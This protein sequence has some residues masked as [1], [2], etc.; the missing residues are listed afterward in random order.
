MK[1][2]RV[3]LCSFILI[4][5]FIQLFLFNSCFAFGIYSEPMKMQYRKH[6]FMHGHNSALSLLTIGEGSAYTRAENGSRRGNFTNEPVL[7][8]NGD[9]SLTEQD[10]KI[11]GKGLS[12]D[13]TRVYNSQINSN[14][15]G[16]SSEDGS[17]SW[18]IENMEYSGDGGGTFS[19]CS[20]QDAVIEADLKTI[21]PGQ[22]DNEAGT[23]YFRFQSDVNYYFFLIH[24]DGTLELG[25]WRYSLVQQSSAYNPLEWNHIKI[26]TTG[27]LV[28]IYVNNNLEISYTDPTPI[29]SGRVGLVSYDSHAHFDNVSVNDNSTVIQN[30]DFE[31]NA[32]GWTPEIGSGPWN[33][34]Q[35]AYSGENG[36]SVS[37]TSSLNTTLICQMKTIVPGA[38]V[39]DV[40]WFNFRYQNANNRYYFYI[41][42]D[43][44]LVLGRFKN[45][46]QTILYQGTNSSYDPLY[47]NNL[48]ISAIQG[49]IRVWINELLVAQAQDNDPLPEGKVALEAKNSHAHFDNISIRNGAPAL[50]NDFNAPELENNTAFGNGWT[51]TYETKIFEDPQGGFIT[52]RGADGAKE[53]YIKKSDGYFAS[54]RGIYSILTK[55]A[56]GYTLREKDG[57][58]YTFDLNGNLVSIKDRNNNQISISYADIGGIQRPQSATDASGR[59]IIFE[60]GLNGK[61]SKITYPASEA[62]GYRQINY[63]YDGS[64]LIEVDFPSGCKKIY[65]Y[66]PLT[67]NL[68]TYTDSNNQ[69]TTYNYYYSDK[70][71]EEID[72]DNQLTAFFYSADSTDVVNSRNEYTTYTFGGADSLL[73]STVDTLYQEEINTWDDNHNL[74]SFQDKL[75]R[76]TNYEYDA[77]G[78]RTKITKHINGLSDVVTNFTYE[79][80]FNQVTSITDPKGNI[81]QFIYDPANGNLLKIIDPA[82]F[83]YETIMTYDEFGNLKTVTDAKGNIAE[84]EYDQYGN[85]TKIIEAKGVLNYTTNF[86]Y[87]VLSQLTITTDANGHSNT[88]EYDKA[89]S[90]IKTTDSLGNVTQNSYDGNGNRLTQ[91][92]YL[93][94]QPITTSYQYDWANNLIKETK[95]DNIFTTYTYDLA[96]F[97]HLGVADRLT[98]TDAISKTTAYE[99]DSENRLIKVTDPNNNFTQYTYDYAGNLTSIA[100]A[101][102]HTINYEYDGLNRLIYVRYPDLT[103]EAFTYDGNGNLLTKTKQNGDIITYAYD[104]LNRMISKTYPDTSSVT[105]QYDSVD[106]LTSTTDSNGTIS[107]AYNAVN[108]LTSVNYPQGYTVNYEYDPAGNRTRLIYPSATDLRY[109]YDANNQLSGLTKNGATLANYAYDS[110]ERRVQKNLLNT[111]TKRTDYSYDKNNQLLILKNYVYTK[112]GKEPPRIEELSFLN[113]FFDFFKTKEAQAQTQTLPLVN[114]QF[115]YTYD[116]VGNRL[117]MTAPNGIH[118]YT[119][120]NIYELTGVSGAQTHNYQYDAVGNRQIVDG[121]NYSANN[122]NQYTA[123][124]AQPFSYDLNGNLTN[125]GV[126]AYTYDYENRLTSAIGNSHNA[127]YVYDPFGRRISRTVDG[128]TTKFIYE[129]DRIIEERDLNNQLI[130]SYV[131]GEGID[132]ILTM[133]KEAQTY[134]YF[135]DGLGSVTDITDNSGNVVESYQYDVYGQPNITSTI[136]NRFMFTGREY[137]NETGL[138]YYRARYYSPTIGRFLQKDPLTWTPSDE[139]VSYQQDIVSD[140]TKSLLQSRGI[141]NTQLLHS[142]NY[143]ANNPVNL[144]DSMGLSTTKP[145]WQKLEEG[146]YY[147]TGYGERAVSWYASRWVETRNPLYALGGGLSAL[148]TP[149]TWVQTSVV[150][151]TGWLSAGWASRTGP[152]VGFK[153][154]EITLTSQTGDKFFRANPLGNPSSQNPLGRR[155]HYHRR[156]GIEKHRPWERGW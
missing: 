105:Y 84:Y 95:P 83:N 41:T 115:I 65:T 132:E 38:G 146:Y 22:Y 73:I 148:W 87:D 2:L 51:F 1:Q 46:V 96:N 134:Y 24:T 118:N 78:N 33:L 28:Q 27:N 34:E 109:T 138:Y 16:W 75:G 135:Y 92:V 29:L 17:G 42:S 4:V 117:T 71:S 116:N 77:Q 9:L 149:D 126:Y 102:Q 79:P 107:N 155:S 99:Y 106:N 129:A 119:Y 40:G 154:G 101:N 145:W 7:L 90:L 89:G 61:I 88:Y 5:I 70:V 152:V 49:D 19:A 66:Y 150:L 114:S 25:K 6:Y 82:P 121:I 91:T 55:T 11:P 144:L 153:G 3:Y 110:L 63:L 37:D 20:Y 12:L 120:N 68:H 130:T 86:S 53:R 104:N 97:L 142:Y 131:Y 64:N 85:R 147:G 45:G 124:G 113:P 133:A 47:W 18:S 8:Q 56:T 21:T 26:I 151:G 111:K 48:K 23:L 112:P 139:R 35:G 108:R 30:N 15:D 143:V 123:V 125:D 67:G 13:I 127:S 136:G 72:P 39:D 80:T 76:L 57:T 50:S 137:D 156:P 58:I 100:D 36:R 44:Q 14:I 62:P 54:P 60:Y 43:K 140:M 59:Q 31:N 98:V 94:G 10:I 122:L 81:T 141:F 128:I 93:N 74:I 103:R 32:S 69:T 52:I